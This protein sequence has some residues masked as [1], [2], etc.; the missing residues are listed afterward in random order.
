MTPGVRAPVRPATAVKPGP[1]DRLRGLARRIS[2]L[3]G[4]RRLAVALAT[5]VVSAA[6]TA[7]FGVWPILFLTFPVLV[8]L[9]D[10]VPKGLRGLAPAF[11]IG[12]FFGFGYLMASLWWIGNAF[13]VEA[14]VFAWL[15]PLAVI[16]MPAGLALFMGWASARQNCSGRAMRGASAPSPPALRVAN[17]CAAMC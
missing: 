4:W 9:I 10:G 14:D 13:L 7:P 1:M 17:G 5:G 3:T 12:W 16:S 2:L 8:F 15:L 6:S 11:G